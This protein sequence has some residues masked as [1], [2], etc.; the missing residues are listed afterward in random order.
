M[1]QSFSLPRPP[2]DLSICF[3]GGDYAEGGRLLLDYL[4]RHAGLQP[5]DHVLDVGCGAGR[6]AYA[7]AGY[8]GAEGRYLGFDTYP[9]GVDW[10]RDNITPSHP[11]FRFELVDVYSGVY[12]P[13][14]A[15]RASEFRFPCADGSFDLVVLNSVFTHMLPA[16]MAH[17]LDEIARVL[18]PGGR[19]FATYYFMNDDARSRMAQGRSNPD[20]TRSFGQFHVA[21]PTSMEDA[22]AFEEGLVRKLLSRSGLE[23]EKVLYGRWC[24]RAEGENG[25]DMLVASRSAQK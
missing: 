7:L 9:F 23:V 3:G 4:V 2:E 17:Y 10:C 20:F 12:N 5:C 13:F 19:M 22:V 18:R 11:N 24:G 6:A 1:T 8:L 16:D 15:V 21:D 14:G 25:Q